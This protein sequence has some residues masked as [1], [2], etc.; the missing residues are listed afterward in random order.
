M[1]LTEDSSTN[2]LQIWCIGII[3]AAVVIGTTWAHMAPEPSDL[4][5]IQGRL[6]RVQAVWF[7]G[8]SKTRAFELRITPTRGETEI[9]YLHEASIYDRTRN[10]YDIAKIE[11]LLGQTVSVQRPPVGWSI[12]PLYEKRVLHWPPASRSCSL[13]TRR[14]G[15]NGGFAGGWL[16]SPRRS[17]C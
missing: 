12:N 14:L 7:G 13:M 4:L 3:L 8:K 10:V 17:C 6:E 1:R 5:Q 16:A 11:A 2:T 9:V 15:T